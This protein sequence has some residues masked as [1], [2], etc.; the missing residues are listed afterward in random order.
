MCCA[1]PQGLDLVFY[2]DSITESWRGT[3]LRVAADK[4]AGIPAIFAKHYGQL[5][6]AAYGIAGG[7]PSLP[8]VAHAVHAFYDTSIL[9]VRVARFHLALTI[10]QK[11]GVQYGCSTVH[12]ACS[13]MAA[14]F[15]TN[16]EQWCCLLHN[17]WLEALCWSA[18]LLCTL[19][20]EQS[21]LWCILQ[22][23]CCCA[24]RCFRSDQKTQRSAAYLSQYTAN[25]EQAGSCA[26]MCAQVT[27]LSIF[28]GDCRMGRV[29]RG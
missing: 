27:R 24:H 16:R 14:C 8:G 17:L 13:A 25:S 12:H 28:C 5:K 7:Y 11:L 19:M 4:F 6:A 15:A 29:L 21:R 2:G 1:L 10:E 3:Q 23:R 20:P 26:C 9:S 22:A 18:T